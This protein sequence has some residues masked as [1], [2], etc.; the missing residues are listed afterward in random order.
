MA[1]KPAQQALQREL[2]NP[3]HRS[4]D[5]AAKAAGVPRRTAHRWLMLPEFRAAIDQAES[6]AIDATGRRLVG[7]LQDVEAVYLAVMQD[8]SQPAVVRLRAASELFNMCMR[9]LEARNVERR[10][11]ELEQ[12]VYE[13]QRAY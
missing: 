9:L 8:E 10:L 3:G 12:V 5:A 4:I 6:E 13:T 2:L 11:A 1:L 7:S